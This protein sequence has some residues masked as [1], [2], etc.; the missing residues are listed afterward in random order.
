MEV[1]ERAPA[2]ASTWGRGVTEEDAALLARVHEGIC[3][4]RMEVPAIFMMESLLPVAVLGSQAM[5][6]LAPV[7][8][9]FVNP[10]DYGRLARLLERRDVIEKMMCRLEASL[11]TPRRGGD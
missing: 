11:G 3:R 9:A 7:V 4:Y 10:T 5:H 8:S 6:F 2:P 1:D